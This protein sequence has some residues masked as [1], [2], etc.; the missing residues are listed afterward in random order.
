MRLARVAAGVS[1]PERGSRCWASVF[2]F[3]AA[4]VLLYE[5]QRELRGEIEVVGGLE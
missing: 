2:D 5:P 3:G 4:F 1:S